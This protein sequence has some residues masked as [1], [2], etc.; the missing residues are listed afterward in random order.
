MNNILDDLKTRL[1]EVNNKKIRLETI[2]EQA[3]Q[4]C[5]EIESKYNIH[6]AEEL[7]QLLDNTQK[8]YDEKISEA[9]MYLID[10]EQALKPYED[11]I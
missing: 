7:K 1:Q 11:L 8:E 2:I 6:N 4:Q 5:S 10:A 9:T 3:R